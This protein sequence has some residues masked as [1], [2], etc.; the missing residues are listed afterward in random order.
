MKNKCTLIIDGN[1]LLNSRMA[2]IMDKFNK[3]LD[4]ALLQTAQADLLDRLARSIVFILNK[5][6]IIDNIVLVS[7]G[8]SWRKKLPKPV[9]AQDIIYKGNRKLNVEKD[10]NYIFG[11]LNELCRTC[12]ELGITC[13]NHIDV[14]GDDWCWYWSR[15]LNE[16]GTNCIIWSVDNDLKQLVQVNNGAF[17]AWY[18]NDKTGLFLHESLKEQPVD[19]IDFFLSPQTESPL[20]TALKKSVNNQVTY[21]N[22]SDI[23]TGKIIC[24][25]SGDNIKS[26]VRQVRGSKTYRI[27][28]KVW[29][30][31]SK[32][33]SI[34]NVNDLSGDKE[35]DLI[36][37]LIKNYPDVN[38]L[39]YDNLYEMIEY[40]KKLVWLDE[41]IIPETIISTMNECNYCIY[42]ISYIRSNYK[43]LTKQNTDIENIFDSI[44]F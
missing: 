40:N 8:G 35:D 14:E 19:N 43:V 27:S 6:P 34:N 36:N 15:R 24:G 39:C 11:A 32:E 21:I 29:D 31:L 12:N 42:D 38:N 23:I 25:D 5:F 10:W 44:V 13:S 22:P 2:I 3:D 18:C 26:V 1:W 37:R 9:L 7:D 41:K 4:A 30:K 33:L 17:T 20:L 16:D 28:E